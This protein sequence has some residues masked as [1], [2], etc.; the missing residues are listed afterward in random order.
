[1]WSN[2]SLCQRTCDERT[3][4]FNDTR[5]DVITSGCVCPDGEYTD[6]NGDCVTDAVCDKCYVNGTLV[7]VSCFVF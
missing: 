1:M 5:C 2:Y 7:D 3:G 4:D 6:V